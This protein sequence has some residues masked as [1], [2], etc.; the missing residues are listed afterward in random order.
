MRK[1]LRSLL[2]TGAVLAT[3]AACGDDVTIAPN[4][5]VTVGPDGASIPIGGTVQMSAAVN[6]PSGIPTTVTW[7]SSNPSVASISETGLVTGVTAGPVA[8]QACSTENTSAC[9]Q[10]TVTVLAQV[11]ATVS[12]QS[13]TQTVIDA[14]GGA[15]QVPVNVNNV[16]GQ[17]EVVLNFE[18]GSTPATEVQVLIDGEV[19]QSQAFSSLQWAE[20]VANAVEKGGE[21]ADVVIELSVV[22]SHFNPET[23]VPDYF[24]G[25][26]QM[27][28]RA[29][30]QGGDQ[31]ATPSQT[32]VFNNASGFVVTL[33]TES[34]AADADG[35]LWTEGDITGTVLPVIYIEGVTTTS[36]FLDPDDSCGGGLATKEGTSNTWAKA[37]SV[38]SGGSR[39]FETDED[40]CEPDIDSSVLSNGQPGPTLVLN[41]TAGD[42]P[43]L[44]LLRHDNAAPDG[45]ILMLTEQD[46]ENDC[47]SG[48]WFGTAYD[49]AAGHGDVIGTEPTDDGVG[50]GTTTYHFGDASLDPEEI[51]AL[52]AV[53]TGAD[54]PETQTVTANTIAAKSCD[55]LNNCTGDADQPSEP[56]VVLVASPSNPLATAGSDQTAPTFVYAA[57][58]VAADAIFNIATGIAGPHTFIA[59][60]SDNLSSFGLNA[61]IVR[62]F[63]N[64]STTA[65]AQCFTPAT[66]QVGWSG[67][68]AGGACPFD[69]GSGGFTN[70]LTVNVPFARYFTDERDVRDQA[71]N[72]PASSLTRT[73]LADDIL[74]TVSNVAIPPSLVGGAPA[75]FTAAAADGLDLGTAA[76]SLEFPSH[77]G[78]NALPF[79]Q[80]TEIS[81][82]GEPLVTEHN[83]T[84]TIP[85]VR[86]MEAATPAPAG[87]VPP[88]ATGARFLIT[89]VAGNFATQVNLFAAATVPAGVSATTLNVATFQVATPSAA[90]DVCNVADCSGDIPTSLTITVTA[91]GPVGSFANP[92]SVVHLYFNDGVANRL[93][94]SATSAASSALGPVLTWTWTFTFD[95]TGLAVQPGVPIFA[96]GV[97]GAG[98]GLFSQNNVNLSII[99]S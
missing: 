32:L 48:N 28:A 99:D 79:S 7:S 59:T 22:T 26:R 41:G 11:P 86:S 88:A 16:F 4:I 21:L 24:N 90:E 95:A 37:T 31:V 62:L 23:G 50:M 42:L 87:G 19:A 39:E 94:G 17:I 78:A 40:G 12:I 1:Y 63:G 72:R 73:I 57:G 2:W 46:A 49:F 81:T 20:L 60:P 54:V 36:V 61:E 83:A 34:S 69:L 25:P 98:D 85:F 75:T 52:P 56:P 29:L 38:A 71:G 68:F 84:A 18:P 44:P 13:I 74:P 91:T 53:A 64:F 51:I 93:V 80:P 45:G 27:S 55:L 6:G 8:I 77:A 33:A 3:V 58:S 66:T 92:F 96:V 35:L 67:T 47:C 89:D 43:A 14:L 65:T 9:G 76:F 30:L 5:T 82:F 10:A 15:T 70:A 97:S